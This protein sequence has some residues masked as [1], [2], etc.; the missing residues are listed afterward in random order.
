[1]IKDMVA[2]FVGLVLY[3]IYPHPIPHPWPQFF[4]FKLECMFF[5]RLRRQVLYMWHFASVSC[6][7]GIVLFSAGCRK[8]NTPVGQPVADASS[9]TWERSQTVAS[10]R[11]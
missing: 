2:V 5:Q 11:T 6:R 4:S 8:C 1:M 10:N 9:S 3:S 7:S